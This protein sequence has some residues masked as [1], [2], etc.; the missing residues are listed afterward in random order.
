[1]TKNSLLAQSW[2]EEKAQSSSKVNCLSCLLAGGQGKIR[3][4]RGKKK[5]KKASKQ[6]NELLIRRLASTITSST[7]L[8]L[9]TLQTHVQKILVL[10][11]RSPTAQGFLPAR[12][13]PVTL[14]PC[15]PRCP[16]SAGFKQAEAQTEKSYSYSDFPPQT[17]LHTRKPT[18]RG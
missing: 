3:S 16:P 17:I 7:F 12:I 18:G 8:R 6:E 5:K 14:V 4:Y 1:M 11:G 9:L 13:F 2:W 15:R 10:S